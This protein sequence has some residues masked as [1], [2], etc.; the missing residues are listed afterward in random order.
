MATAVAPQ[1][2]PGLLARPIA[3]AGVWSWLTTVDAKRIGGLY[4]AENYDSVKHAGTSADPWSIAALDGALAAIGSAN[5]VLILTGVHS[6]TA[7]RTIPANVCLN[8]AM[9]MLKPATGVT[10]TINGPLKAPLSKAFDLVGTGVVAFG[11]GAVE[12]FYPQWW[13]A[14]PLGVSDSVAAIQA[15]INAANAAGGGMVYF[16]DG[17]YLLSTRTLLSGGIYYCL[18]AKNNVEIKGQSRDGT[19]LKVGNG[20]AANAIAAA[21]IL[22]Q[23]VNITYRTFTIDGNRANNADGGVDGNQSGIYHDESLD[24]TYDDLH[25]KN[26]P[27]IGLYSSLN[28]RIRATRVFAE[29][30]GAEGISISGDAYSRF[31]L[32]YATACG[33]SATD[34]TRSGVYISG[35]V[36]YSSFGTIVG[37]QNKFNGISLISDGVTFD[38]EYNHFGFLGSYNNHSPSLGSAGGNAIQLG[39]GGGSG[40]QGCDFGTIVAELSRT[41]GIAMTNVRNCFFSKVKAFNGV[42]HGLYMT[43]VTDLTFGHVEAY[44]DRGGLAD[45]D[46]GIYEDVGCTNIRVL[47]GDVSRGGFQTTAIN[48]QAASGLYLRRIKG[49]NPQGVAAISVTASP[50]TYTNN[51]GVPEAVYIN[52]VGGG[53][54]TDISKNAISISPSAPFT[55]WLEPGEACI[56]TYTGA[57]ASITMKKDRK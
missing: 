55:V 38:L 42:L 25:F 52:N 35:P 26:C 11:T 46:W 15:A 36:R 2:Q 43:N 31:D 19:I 5:A 3:P 50:F 6:I 30:C 10:I 14:D 1:P 23:P 12:K 29:N 54:V 28:I 32:L 16:P 13:G 57:V 17:T 47:S 51:D 7:N 22:G 49:F 21:L 40:P 53:T 24:C 8:V 33:L 44:D 20:V 34:G 18:Y 45:Q 56:T 27:R 9:G 37:Y 39:V 41:N 4:Y 48:L